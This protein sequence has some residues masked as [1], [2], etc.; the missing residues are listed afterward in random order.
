SNLYMIFHTDGDEIR[1]RALELLPAPLSDRTTIAISAD[2]LHHGPDTAFDVNHDW[3]ELMIDRAAEAIAEAVTSRRP[4]RLL[5]GETDHFF[6]LGDGRD[7]RILD[8]TMGVLQATATNGRKIATLVFWGNH[9]EVTL[10]WE[11][12][13]TALGE[14][15]QALGIVDD[16]SAEG[17]YL[18]SDFPGAM[19][20]V[21]EERV[22]G[23]ALFFNGALGGLV[24]PLRAAVW[25]ITEDHQLG[26]GLSPPEGASA[27]GGGDDYQ[28]R[29]FRRAWVIGEQLAIAA[30]AALEDGHQLTH[31]RISYD[32][33]PFYT[34]LTHR[35]FRLLSVVDPETGFTRL[36]HLPAMLYGCPAEGPKDD[37]TC[38]PDQFRTI[39]DEVLGE[40]R[41]GDHLR[42]EVAYLR[43]GPVGVMFVPAEIAPEL[44][45]GLPAG[46]RD[47]PSLWHAD[48]PALHAF[49]A[50]YT[51]PGY[52][53]NRMDDRYRWMV[54]LGN[55]ELGYVIPI[56]DWRVGCVADLLSGP[57]ACAQLHQAG[58][59]EYPDAVAGATCRTVTDDPSRLGDYPEEA[60]AGMA[61]SCAY[62]QVLVEAEGHYEETNSAGWDLADDILRTVG[63]LTGDYSDE[64]V[65]PDFPGHWGGYPP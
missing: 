49:G 1:R 30:L 12:P 15:C 10:G 35:G 58:V 48:D 5:V 31:P 21:I 7:P 61:A 13:S 4:A 56:S 3:F 46:Y 53:K 22:G 14:D 32:S 47:D 43:I 27:P 57:G 26:D 23:L 8:P 51:G 55:D 9:P 44:V 59:I 16:C 20:E 37:E 11:P 25:E 65:N 50:E 63:D 64:M 36:G 17:R 28:N 6:G 39:P 62:G 29:N 52:V 24:T 19:A 45:I 41:E 33:Q 54:G 34:R 60:A 38:A 2:H 40:I 18:T 42:S